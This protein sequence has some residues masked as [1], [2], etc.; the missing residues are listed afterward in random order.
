M[1]TL[2]RKQQ[3]SGGQ[4]DLGRMST[5]LECSI[6]R[7]TLNAVEG[8]AQIVRSTLRDCDLRKVPASAF[9]DCDLHD[10]RL[11]RG[12]DERRNRVRSSS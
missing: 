1:A 3:I 2:M 5:V 11:P 9:D 6:T 8:E 12:F 10:C 7:V 4:L